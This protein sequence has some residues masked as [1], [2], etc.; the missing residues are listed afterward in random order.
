M[1][2]LEGIGKGVCRTSRGGGT[3]LDRESPEVMEMLEER[4]KGVCRTSR[5]VVLV[6]IENHK[7]L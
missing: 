3:G 4:G 1:E 2:M 5:G 7:G 6:W